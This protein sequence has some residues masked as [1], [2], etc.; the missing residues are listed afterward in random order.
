VVAIGPEQVKG[1]FVVAATET[2]EFSDA[3]TA[4]VD[5]GAA[6]FSRAVH[7]TTIVANGY[8]TAAA[9]FNNYHRCRYYWCC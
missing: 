1:A 5:D 6:I 2:T 4:A 9:F 7:C 3:A 8:T